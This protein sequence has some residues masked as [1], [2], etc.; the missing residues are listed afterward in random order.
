MK[1]NSGYTKREKGEQGQRGPLVE[2]NYMLIRK[3]NNCPNITTGTKVLYARGV[4]SE[5]YD[6]LEQKQFKSIYQS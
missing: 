2:V 5:Y 4:A 6:I 3:N 1:S